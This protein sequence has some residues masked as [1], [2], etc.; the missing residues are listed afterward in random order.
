MKTEKPQLF[1]MITKDPGLIILLPGF[2]IVIIIMG[3]Y[4][5]QTGISK[6]KNGFAE[7]ENG[8]ETRNS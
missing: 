2:T 4:F 7:Q 6:Y 3:W 5:Y 8:N 1:L